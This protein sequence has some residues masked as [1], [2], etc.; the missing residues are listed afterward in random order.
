MNTDLIVGVMN[1]Q[2]KTVCMPGARFKNWMQALRS[3]NYRQGKHAL[4]TTGTDGTPSFCCLGVEQACNN[5]GVESNQALP[6]TKYM[7]DN[8]VFYTDAAGRFRTPQIKMGLV[9]EVVPEYTK[10]GPYTSISQLNDENIPFETL[11]TL[12]ERS[13]ISL[14]KIEEL[15]KKEHGE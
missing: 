8:N 9:K 6:T 15:I 3:G 10:R 11:A 7:E 2:G 14:E 12:L 5:N 13:F 1:S 4:T